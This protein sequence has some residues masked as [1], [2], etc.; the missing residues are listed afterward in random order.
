MLASDCEV[1]DAEA[2]G[3]RED[4]EFAQA[5]SGLLALPFVAIFVIYV[6]LGILYESFMH[7]LTILS[8]LPFAALGALLTLWIFGKDLGV[9]SYAGTIMLI[10]LVKKNAIMML[11]F[12]IEAERD[13]LC[14]SPRSWARCRSPSVPVRSGSA[15]GS[16]GPVPG[17]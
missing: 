9:Y 17:D 6:V 15:S 7:P 12:A 4:R 1:A 13:L 8:A 16:S 5:Q 11:D 3:S 2:G 10:G 14:R